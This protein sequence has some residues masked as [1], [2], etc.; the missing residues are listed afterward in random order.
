M[1]IMT[2]RRRDP[3]L[4]PKLSIVATG[5]TALAML[6]GL[7]SADTAAGRAGY[8]IIGAIAAALMM[9]GVV[10]LMKGRKR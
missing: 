5:F 10:L 6:I 4:G 3:Y 7:I 9:V 1:L 2:E 8:G